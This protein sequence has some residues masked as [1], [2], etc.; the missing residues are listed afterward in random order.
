MKFMHSFNHTQTRWGRVITCTANYGRSQVIL[1]SGK[2][3]SDFVHELIEQLMGTRISLPKGLFA[4]YVLD[5]A[6]G[7]FAEV[8]LDFAHPGMKIRLRYDEEPHRVTIRSPC[9]AEATWET[10]CGDIVIKV[11]PWGIGAP[12]GLRLH[13]GSLAGDDSDSDE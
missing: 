7:R 12:K 11:T 4:E 8:P 13:F 9:G 3:H 10:D 2:V 6:E 5:Q 1:L